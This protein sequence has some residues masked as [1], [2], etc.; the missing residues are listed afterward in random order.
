MGLCNSRVAAEI[1]SAE[2]NISAPTTML[3]LEKVSLIRSF[4]VT[5]CRKG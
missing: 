5:G 4:E 3:G 1:M 2:R